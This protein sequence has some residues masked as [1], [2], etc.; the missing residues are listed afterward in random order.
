MP[1]SLYT[2]EQITKRRE[3]CRLWYAENREAVLKKKKEQRK[4]DPHKANQREKANYQRNKEQIK[5]RSK[6]YKAA[7]KETTT[8]TITAYRK[9]HKKEINKQARDRYAKDPDKYKEKLRQEHKKTYST[10]RGRLN[11]L[12]SGG[13]RKSVANGKQGRHWETLV[14]YTL[15][16]LI[17]HLKKKLPKG[18]TWNEYKNNPSKYH[19]DHIIPKA[20]F[21]FSKIEH[22][23]FKKCW[24]LK[25]LQVLSAKQNQT[26]HKKLDK[27]FQPSLALEMVA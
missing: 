25:N 15:K 13:I 8:K 26:K 17:E 19:I 20:I 7:N 9:A 22:L 27:P 16:D 24:A 3:Q 18:V 5:E 23:D 14:G 4:E 2:P 12:M 6:V 10:E 11:K 21:N 1:K